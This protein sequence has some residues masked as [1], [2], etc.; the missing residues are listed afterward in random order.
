MLLSRLFV[1][2]LEDLQLNIDQIWL[3]TDSTIVLNWLA[4]E[5]QTWKTYVANRVAE[6]QKNTEIKNWRHVPSAQNPA[7]LITRGS[8]LTDLIKNKL[9]W[10]GPSF[11]LKPI[12]NWPQLNFKTPKD[13]NPDTLEKRKDKLKINNSCFAVFLDTN[14]W[15]NFIEKYSKLKTLVRVFAYVQRFVNNVKSKSHNKSRITGFL[16][17][18]EIKSALFFFIRLV[19]KTHFEQDFLRLKNKRPVKTESNLKSLNPFFDASDELIRV[20]GRLKNT[21]FDYAQ[22]HP[23]LL[24]NKP[25]NCKINSAFSKGHKLTRLIITDEHERALHAGP[26]ATL[27]HVRQR[28]WP[29]HGKQE[30]KSVTQKCLKCFKINPK[31]TSYLMGDLPSVRVK[32]SRP[33]QNT[34]VDY[35]GPF[36]IKDSKNRNKK[37]LK[38]YVVIFVC[39][40]TRCVH[41]ELVSE[42][43]S[44]GF[45]SMLK[46]FVSRRGFC[47]HLYSDQGTCF[48]GAN[49]QLIK[50]QKLIDSEKFRDYLNNAQMSWHFMPARSPHF[51]GSHEAA[52]KSCKHHLKRILTS[53]HLTYEE[54]Y[55]L[56]TQIEAVLNSRPLVSLSD[57]PNDLE[58]ITPSHFL[59]GHQL[60]TT[61]DEE[62][63]TCKVNRVKRYQHVQQMFQHFW[64]QW[65]ANYLHTLQE[66]SKWRFQKNNVAVGSVVMLKTNDTPPLHWPLGKIIQLHPGTDGVVRVVTL[67]TKNGVVQRAVTQICILPADNE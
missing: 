49:N 48:I 63:T 2:C 58:V 35:A 45:L 10:H 42:L 50:C 34:S 40:A 62:L 57:D 15:L 66:R 3:W 41:I 25:K 12:E 7:D 20:G 39:L 65:S 59:I 13:T 64:K 60:T 67:K 1:K 8:K 22:K 19:Q 36:E 46:R 55:T 52:V 4:N 18:E 54:F 5:P 27:S 26:N 56:L 21:D 23:I 43:T 17:N 53:N 32:P 31:D 37:F 33:F 51:G 14:Y 9:W 11:L 6:I 29:L 38:A 28:Y 47:N 44:D 16:T 61:P 24:P 30:T